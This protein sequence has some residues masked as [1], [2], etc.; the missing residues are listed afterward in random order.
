M[1]EYKR[2]ENS[3]LMWRNKNAGGRRPDFQGRCLIGGKDYYL[4]GWN[5][6][7]RGPGS[8]NLNFALVEEV[9][10]LFEAGRKERELAKLE[11]RLKKS[12]EKKGSCDDPNIQAEQ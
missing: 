6:A 8:V 5:Y 9:K 2:R 1:T 3:G 7:G 11:K 12:V 10:P 4:S